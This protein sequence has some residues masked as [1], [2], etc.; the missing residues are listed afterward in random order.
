VPWRAITEQQDTFISTRYL[1]SDS[2]LKDPSKLQNTEATELLDFWYRRQE[3]KK[4]PTFQFKGWRDN[5]R[6][7]IDPVDGQDTDSR[8]RGGRLHHCRREQHRPREP[9]DT[10]DSSDSTQSDNRMRRLK[11]RLARTNQRTSDEDSDEST[12]D[13]DWDRGL[14][15]IGES[16]PGDDRQHSNR[17]AKRKEHVSGTDV[18]VVKRVRNVQVRAM[19]PRVTRSRST[20]KA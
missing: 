3:A 1:P 11:K 12:V 13:A 9:E 7:M 5:D 19:S 14:R 18:T 10:S 16:V 8:H 2:L 15:G 4:T 20:A 17:Q 6:E